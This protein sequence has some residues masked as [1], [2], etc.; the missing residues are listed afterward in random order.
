MSPAQM[1][2]I[3]KTYLACSPF[4][5]L[6][7]ILVR[8]VS[9]QENPHQANEE[10]V[11]FHFIPIYGSNSIFFSRVTYLVVDAIWTALCPGT[12]FVRCK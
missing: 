8:E 5:D 12:C 3:D 6:S 10:Q 7:N 4:I 2:A 11:D 1:K 9:N